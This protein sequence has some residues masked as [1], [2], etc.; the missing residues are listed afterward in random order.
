MLTLDLTLYTRAGYHSDTSRTFCAKPFTNDSFA[1]ELEEI[2]RFALFSAL[3]AC[4]PGVPFREIGRIIQRTV[5]VE[6]SGMMSV[7]KQL[8]GH[9]IGRDFHMKPWI[10]HYG[11]SFYNRHHCDQLTPKQDNN[12]PGEMKP[13]HCFTI[14]VL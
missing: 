6:S 12:E 14:E 13:G 4:G 10:I 9:G 1:L 8:T 7:V 3:E 11:N 5:E 2:T